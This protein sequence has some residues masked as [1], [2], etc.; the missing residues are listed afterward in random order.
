MQSQGSRKE[1]DRRVKDRDVITAAD[2]RVM[3]AVSLRMQAASRSRA[4]QGNTFSPSLPKRYSPAH[5]N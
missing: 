4:R 5:P 3:W 2:I 1:G